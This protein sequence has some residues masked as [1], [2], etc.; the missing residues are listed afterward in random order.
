MTTPVISFVVAMDRNRLIGADGNLPWRLPDD[1]KH[2]RRVTM[3]KPVL[4]GRVTYESIP[5]RFRP[6]PGRNNIILTR[7]EDYV[8]PDCLVVHSLDEALASAPDQPELM[9]IGGAQ[10]FEQLLPQADRLYLTLIDG[11]FEGNV[12]FPELD[13]GQWQERSRQ[14][15]DQDDKHPVPFTILLLERLPQENKASFL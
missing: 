4:M 2:F 12:Y 11:E 10:I 7:Q 1:M 3:G 8:A 14:T 9:V 5:E 15:H 13:M 6:L